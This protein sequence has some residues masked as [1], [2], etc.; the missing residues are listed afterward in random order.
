MGRSEVRV[1]WRELAVLMPLLSG[2]V[3][4]LVVHG[5]YLINLYWGDVTACLPY[6]DGCVSISRAVRSGPGILLF[7]ATMFPSVVLMIGS[8]L[9][10][11]N[12]LKLMGLPVGKGAK[13]MLIL[14]VAG[15]LF[16]ILYVSFLGLDGD[17]AGAMRRIGVNFY[18]GFTA[19]AQLLLINIV[20]PPRNRLDEG[21]LCKAIIAL[22]IVVAA[23]WFLGVG[24]SGKK[25]F[26]SNPFFL[27]RIES[28]IEWLF[29]LLMSLGF[30]AI[31]FLL[32]R[33]NTRLAMRRD[34]KS[35]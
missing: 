4:I 27:D 18:F 29:A 2:L 23:L 8:W 25:L 12:W 30:V 1:S 19:V 15:P 11:Y 13:A 5:A 33:S 16:M 20:W 34:S 14:G 17:V 9:L 35:L 26:I 32:K 7:R 28:I 22:T 3:P 31:A 24:F 10:V 21:Q 6:W